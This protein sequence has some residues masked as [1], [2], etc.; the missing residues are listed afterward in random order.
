MLSDTWSDIVPSETVVIFEG[1][2][3]E[4]AAVFEDP[5]LMCQYFFCG[6]Y[7]FIVMI[8]S[9]LVVGLTESLVVAFFV[10]SFG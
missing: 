3:S 7:P 5:G 8:P 1:P 6:N 9:L 10:F 4:T 2:A